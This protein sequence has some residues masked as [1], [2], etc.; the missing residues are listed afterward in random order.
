M[1]ADDCP[2]LISTRLDIY[3]HEVAEEHGLTKYERE[4]ALAVIER[5]HEIAIESG[6]R[7]LKLLGHF[8]VT[9]SEM[10]AGLAIMRAADGDNAPKRADLLAG[11]SSQP[12]AYLILEVLRK[13]A[14]KALPPHLANSLAEVF[15]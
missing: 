8:P 13:T 3:F 1:D 10:E 6:K 7:M 15:S 4:I 9:D 11:L 14:K 2:S 12:R 5:F